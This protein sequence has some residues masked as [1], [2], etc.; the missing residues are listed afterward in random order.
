[1]TISTATTLDDHYPAGQLLGWAPAVAVDPVAHLALTIKAARS[2]LILYPPVVRM[3]AEGRPELVGDAE[4]SVGLLKKLPP[5]T[6][7]RAVLWPEELPPLRV[8]THCLL[9][10]PDFAERAES[11]MPL[12]PALVTSHDKKRDIAQALQVHPAQL[13][14]WRRHD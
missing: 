1:M 2:L 13:T 7:V 14:R 8:R 4:L 3:T 12:L 11:L 10:Q 9:R 5:A 6:V